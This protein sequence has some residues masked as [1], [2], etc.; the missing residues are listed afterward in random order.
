MREKSL[1]DEGWY[2]HR[3][4]IPVVFPPDK[5][6]AY[7]GAKMER[8]YLGPAARG[9]R[10]TDP[11]DTLN[12]HNSEKW[13]KVDLPH[14]YLAYDIPNRDCN[15]ALGFC[16]YE[17]AW[18]RKK[19]IL[20]NKD[21]GSRIAFYFEG[22]SSRATVWLNGC[23]LY[24]N[25]SGYTPFEV[26]VTDTVVFEQENVLSVF[27]EANDATHEGWW[28]EGAGICRHVYMIK[29][30]KFSVDTH[31]VYINPQ[32]LQ[33]DIWHCPIEVTL[34]CDDNTTRL[35]RAEC[36][37][38]D[39]SGRVLAHTSASGRLEARERRVMRMS[40]DVV[41]PLLWSPESPTLYRLTV[42]V[43]AGR[44]E[45]LAD[46]VSVRFGFRSFTMDPEK[47]LFINGKPT[48]IKGFCVHENCG[49]TGRVVP[50]NIQRYKLQLL[51]EMGANGFRASHYPHP[52][53]TM[54]AL[55]EMGFIVMDEVRWFD[56]SP[57]GL[58]ELETLVKRDR[59]H[60]SVFFWSVGNEEPH[61]LTDVGR[62]VFLTMKNHIRMLDD[63]PVTTAI[64]HRPEDA[65]MLEDCDLIGL[66]YKWGHYD[67]VRRRCP[68]KPIL[69]SECGAT[70]T[71]RGWYHPH[72]PAHGYMSAYDSDI[73]TAFRSREYTWSFIMEHPWMMGG[74]HWHGFEYRGEAVWPRTCSV[75]GA[76]DLFLQKKDAFWQHA[77]YFTDA[78]MI[79][80]LPHWNWKGLEGQPIRVVAYTNCP[81]A[82]L[83]L[84]GE[85]LG[86]V[87]VPRYS[88]AEWQVPY[89]P[90]KLTVRALDEAGNEV[91]C[92]V[93]ETTGAPARLKLHLD[94][95]NLRPGDVAILSCTVL[96]S[97]GREV[98]DAT[99]TVD[100][101]AEG[102]G[103]LIATG[104][105]NTD[106]TPLESPV[107]RM[108]AGRA[109]AAV[110][111]SG[112]KGVCRVSVFSPGVAADSVEF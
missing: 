2:F 73:N 35:L 11:F 99:C 12:A 31:G 6:T 100:F 79:H 87:S 10:V 27:V 67:Q 23:L 26:D 91:A 13:E 92:D 97:E 111:L 24:H 36:E 37:I 14:D 106:H 55:D 94:T 65:T 102:T 70:G 90:G 98:K 89:K 112:K 64:T 69:S 1:F 101:I 95:E 19:F 61:H 45:D 32:K 81:Q 33:G 103:S 49:F 34:R 52:E 54:D 53:A 58:A 28:Y 9:Y 74:F 41:D 42:R 104:A 86:R 4:D 78:P 84:D 43:Y 75:S 63:R 59:N 83:F 105:D 56:S 3:G 50:D 5:G 108:F 38:S 51:R 88:H 93:Q 60:P 66:N 57:D 17:N 16:K 39:R 7:T 72:D 40:T 109:A 18:Y 82:E 96:D 80:L 21:R 48:K 77:A 20:N 85:S 44:I 22:V 68:D 76:I 107:R 25:R 30:S 110:R 62:R 29:T 8:A 15:E 71:T 46:E 47:G